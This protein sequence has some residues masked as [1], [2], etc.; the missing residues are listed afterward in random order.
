M[1]H[2]ESDDGVWNRSP[3]KKRY[4]AALQNLCTNIQY[5]NTTSALD[6]ERLITLKFRIRE[7][8]IPLKV[9]KISYFFFLFLLNGGVATE[10]KKIGGCDLSELPRCTVAMEAKML[11][12]H[13]G[14]I[15]AELTAYQNTWHRRPRVCDFQTSERPYEFRY[16]KCA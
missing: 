7:Q 4:I 16:L 6:F 15:Y 8:E 13:G 2:C 11:H 9:L 1:D 5:I 10:K 14:K 12:R 3:P